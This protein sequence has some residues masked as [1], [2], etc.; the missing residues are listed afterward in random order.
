MAYL[1]I[2]CILIHTFCGII[3]TN[4]EIRVPETKY[5]CLSHCAL[6]ARYPPAPAPADLLLPEDSEE[7]APEPPEQPSKLEITTASVPAGQSQVARAARGVVRSRSENVIE[8]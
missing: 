2:E 3:F 8:K 6:T 1:G 7:E 4:L 5:L